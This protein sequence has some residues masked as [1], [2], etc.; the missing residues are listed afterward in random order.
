MIFLRHPVTDAPAGLCYG[1]HDVGL[2]AGAE[3]QITRALAAVPR[4]TA[5]ITS[6]LRRCR[7]LAERFAARDGLAIREDPRLMEYD[8]GAWEGR[9]WADIP[10]VESEAW[11]A[12][13]PHA[14]PPGGERFTDLVA[15]VRAALAEITPGTLVI[16]HAG[17]IRAAKMI[18]TGAT[19]DQ[20]FAEK[21]PFCEPLAFERAPV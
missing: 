3:A 9:L 10:R 7:L 13:L 16:C 20:V 17:P 19:F 2:G 11:T 12:N 6:P 15:R 21:I 14:A 18:V 1:R 5:L 4:P 8:F